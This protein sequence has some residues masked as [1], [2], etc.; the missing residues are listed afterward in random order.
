MR[1][2]QAAGDSHSDEDSDDEFDFEPSL[3]HAAN[4]DCTEHDLRAIKHA[5][6]LIASGH[7]DMASRAAATDHRTLD[8][9]DPDVMQQLRHM[10]PAAFDEW[11]M[12][13]LPHDAFTSIIQ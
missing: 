12:P 11:L 6:R 9:N 1:G 10:H 7:M 5:R 2:A 3:A 4:S 8:C 13:A